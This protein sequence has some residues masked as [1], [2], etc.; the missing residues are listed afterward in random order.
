[1]DD[2]ILFAQQTRTLATR[3]SVT[4]SGAVLPA[5]AAVAI[6]IDALDRA[7]VAHGITSQIELRQLRQAKLAADEQDRLDNEEAL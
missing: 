7:R 4:A 6:A 2:A 3:I 1:M 5:E